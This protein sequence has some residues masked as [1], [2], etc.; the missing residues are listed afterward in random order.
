MGGA[1]CLPSGNPSARLPTYNIKKVEQ[2]IV[3]DFSIQLKMIDGSR[4]RAMLKFRPW[5]EARGIGKPSSPSPK[6]YCQ[7]KRKQP[8]I[9][10]SSKP[11]HGAEET[12][13]SEAFPLECLTNFKFSNS[14]GVAGVH[15]R[16]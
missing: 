6:Q 14:A 5:G 15:G 4:S 13:I 9:P 11:Q 1:D 16:R 12:L 2:S 7:I 10:L 8:H 3:R